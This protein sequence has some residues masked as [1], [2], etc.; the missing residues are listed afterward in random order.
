MQTRGDSAEEVGIEEGPGLLESGWRYRLLVVLLLLLGCAAGYGLATVQE[1]RYEGVTTV[2]LADPRG[3]EVF[4][5]DSAPA[6]SNRYVRNQAQLVTSSRVLRDAAARAGLDLSLDELRERVTAEAA[7]DVDVIT[8]RALAGDPEEAARLA[9]AVAVAYEAA[10]AADVASAAQAAIEELESTAAELRQRLAS[11]EAELAAAPDSPALTAERAAAMEQL[12]TV[13][14]RA[15]QLAVDATLTGGGVDL[16]EPAEVPTEPV[17]PRPVR[18]TAAGAALGL[19]LAVALSWWLNG[20]RQSS[21]PRT[22]GERVLGVPLM[23]EIPDFAAAGVDG[24]LPALTAVH[25]MPAEAYEFVVASLA[26]LR[27]QGHQVILVT[28]ARPEEGKTVTTMNLAIAAGREGRRVLLVDADG[29]VRGLTRLVGLSGSADL[30]VLADERTPSD[31]AITRLPLGDGATVGLASVGAA[32]ATAAYFRSPA[33]VTALRRLRGTADLVLI[34]SPPLLAVADA[35]E[36]AQHVDGV[37]LVCGPDTPRQVLAEVRRRLDLVRAPL[38]G[39]VLN[40]SA[41]TASPYAAAY[42]YPQQPQAGTHREARR[43]ARRRRERAPAP[44]PQTEAD[45]TR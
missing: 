21:D 22:Q 37:L 27:Q 28:S 42:P 3:S 38:L 35:A 15:R 23:G 1:V 17:Q 16:H 33:F 36:I 10:V 30:A 44:V 45:P 29:R 26:A 8:I 20:R 40:R 31:R 9:D 43:A 41:P 4:G 18:T 5:E 14:S 34:D 25:S 19:S 11:I 24:P 12:S 2:L 32:A 7:D 6:D 13:L 39:Y